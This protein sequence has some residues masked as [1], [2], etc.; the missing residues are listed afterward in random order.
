[1]AIIVPNQDSWGNYNTRVLT[2]AMPRIVPNQDSWGNYNMFPSAD[3]LYWIVPNQDS[4]GNYNENADV[5]RIMEIVPNQDSWG[6]YND[7]VSH[8][9]FP[10]IVPNQDSWGNYNDVELAGA[11]FNIVPNQ[12]SWGNYNNCFEL[13][14]ICSNCT[15]PRLMRELQHD[16]TVKKGH[17]P[18]YQTKTHEGTTTSIGHW[19]GW[20]P[21]VPNQDS[22]GNYNLRQDDLCAIEIVPNQ[23]SWGNYNLVD[24]TASD[25]I[26]VPNQDSWGNYNYVAPE[27]TAEEIVPNQDSWGNYNFTLAVNRL[28]KNCT[29]P[30]LMRELQLRKPWGVKNTR[31]YQTKTHEGTTTQE[32][33]SRIKRLLYQTKTHEGTTTSFLSV[34]FTNNCTKPR[35]M[36]EL[37]PQS[38]T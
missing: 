22:W 37:Q 7:Y 23:D 38:A 9:H 32:A 4:W 33:C 5:D 19:P 35:L 6:N 20:F 24:C 31:L 16:F 10:S 27:P 15:K 14:R 17:H 8:T 11:V 21:I 18:L 25:A 12:D 1:M 30:R 28:N 36:R 2:F 26:I 34:F 13:L 29:K 3:L